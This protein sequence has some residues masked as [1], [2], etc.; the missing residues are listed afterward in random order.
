MKRQRF[1][2]IVGL[3]TALAVL[4]T[5]L[6]TGAG[7][8][9]AAGSR[10]A[11]QEKGSNVWY[12][13]YKGSNSE[14]WYCGDPT[15][16]GS[17]RPEPGET[18]SVGQ[19]G[20]K[21]TTGNWDSK[22]GPAIG[23]AK[24]RQLAYLLSKYGRTSSD[25][26]AAQLDWA[27]RYLIG[28]GSAVPAG[29]SLENAGR[30]L[31]AEAEKYAGPYEVVPKIYVASNGATASLRDYRPTS[32]NG[33]KMSGYSGTLKISGPATFPNGNKTMAAPAGTPVTLTVAGD[34]QVTVTATW[35]DL[36]AA[37][38][39][40]REAPGNAQDAMIT[41]TASDADGS[42][43]FRSVDDTPP[44]AP[45]PVSADVTTQSSSNE[46]APGDEITDSVV[47]NLSNPGVPY[48]GTATGGLYR[49]GTN[50]Q[51]GNVV[52][53]PFNGAGTYTSPAVRIPADAKP[54][55]KFTWRWTF[56][57]Y[58]DDDWTVAGFQTP[59]AIPAET[60]VVGAF[61]PEVKTQISSQDSTVGQPIRDRIDVSGL[62]EGRKV[63]IAWQLHGPYPTMPTLTEKCEGAPVAS[64]TLTTDKNGSISTPDYVIPEG[65]AGYYT[66]VEQTT[67]TDDYKPA[68]TKCG[69]V[70]ETTLT[71]AQP[72]YRTKVSHQKI[73]LGQSIR[74]AIMIE[75]LADNNKLNITW[76]LYG[77][78]TN[79]PGLD[80]C[81]PAHL[82]KK[83]TV[84]ATRNGTIKTDA[85]TPSKKGYYTYV[86][87]NGEEG[88]H[89]AFATKCGETTETSLVEAP[90]APPTTSSPPLTRIPSGGAGTLG[91]TPTGDSDGGHPVTPLLGLV[92]LSVLCATVAVRRRGSARAGKQTS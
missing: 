38:V 3:I 55:E 75:G 28:G 72:R 53:L 29:G 50:E 8:A 59:D 14:I 57:A 77:P 30:D 71:K 52:S 44:P 60:A 85:F 22:N 31:I 66:Y 19:W 21:K 69:E 64:G 25:T 76:E 41:G 16:G 37:V 61:T 47:L 1:R 23:G 51:I 13:G 78:F 74:D 20:S 40:Y 15:M 70:T 79:R 80:S 5:V 87:H 12:G 82:A 10:A 43:K 62:V 73:E 32:A 81:T 84:V 67:G 27:V 65:K 90:P 68:A 36:P 56:P 63:D 54:Q 35:N 49:T 33:Y 39:S 6:V 92:A 7:P 18:A 89:R 45:S 88:F 17:Y 2:P 11:G 9:S 46:V 26:K 58:A 34:E 24:T 4:V 91:G 83:G 48:S 86:E 42:T